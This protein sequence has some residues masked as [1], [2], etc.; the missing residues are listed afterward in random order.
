[1]CLLQ[2][3]LLFAALLLAQTPCARAAVH[4][5]RTYSQ[6]I[7]A[8][9]GGCNPELI[10]DESKVRGSPDARLGGAHRRLHLCNRHRQGK[11]RLPGCQEAAHAAAIAD[12]SPWVIASISFVMAGVEQPQCP[13]P[14]V[15]YTCHTCSYSGAHMCWPT[16]RSAPLALGCS[17]TSVSTTAGACRY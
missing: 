9:N 8:T 15:K 16:R 5:P 4:I 1:M 3:Q 11:D 17:T 13:A 12:D 2:V 6:L 7:W 10:E 14:D